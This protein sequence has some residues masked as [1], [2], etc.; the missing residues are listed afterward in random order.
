MGQARVFD[1]FLLVRSASRGG[2]AEGRARLKNEG[3][4]VDLIQGPIMLSQGQM[5]IVVVAMNSVP[6][7]L[8]AYKSYN[9]A[10]I[11][12]GGAADR[13][14]AEAAA[15]PIMS[16]SGMAVHLMPAPGEEVERYVSIELDLELT[17]EEDREV[18]TRNMARIREA[19]I[20][21]FGDRTAAELQAE[22]AMTMMKPALVARLN[23]K[24]KRP[25]IRRIYF[26][27]FIIQ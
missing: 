9:D 15:G 16:L 3:G 23:A 21:Y 6:L 11:G 20:G 22:G 19:L 24:L 2:L 17:K 12:G 25:R 27:Q 7:G 1:D 8:V 18:I 5:V 26:D 14:S 4:S 13:P 10:G